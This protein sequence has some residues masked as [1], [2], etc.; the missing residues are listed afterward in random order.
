MTG[1]IQRH[2]QI[3]GRVQGV[4]FRYALRAEAVRLGLSGWVRNRHDGSV[5]A[6]VRGK[7]AAVEAISLWAQ[8]GP[9]AAR[10][11]AVQH[12]DLPDA[13]TGSEFPP[14]FQELPTC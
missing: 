3:S 7:A 12:G 6:L 2:L 8:H 1:V 10:V 4:G 9:R 14:D 5:E 11:D 13:D